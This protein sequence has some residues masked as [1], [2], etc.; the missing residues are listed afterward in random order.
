M[1]QIGKKIE[2]RLQE[3]NMTQKELAEAIDVTETSV[4][5]YISKNRT[6][7]AE[8]LSKISKVLN[9]STEYLLG[10]SKDATPKNELPQL[11]NNIII[12]LKSNEVQIYG[13]DIENKDAQIINIYLESI[14]KHIKLIKS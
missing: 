10:T 7:R 11:I 9:I 2:N 12:Q 13:K 8:I 14:L 5:R 6:P 1:N 4:S 3:L